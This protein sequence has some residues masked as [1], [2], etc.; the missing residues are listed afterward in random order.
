[1]PEIVSFKIT[2]F[3]GAKDV[4][5]QLHHRVGHPVTTLVGLNESGK[6]TILEA[7]SHFTT[8]DTT[9]DDMMAGVG[10]RRDFLSLLPIDLKPAFTGQVSVK[11]TIRITDQDRDDL[12]ALYARSGLVLK[13]E[14]IGSIFS[15]NVTYNFKDSAYVEAGS[16]AFW[17]GIDWEFKSRVAKNFKK[18]SPVGEIRPSWLIAVNH[19]REML[20]QVVYFPTFLVDLP[21]RIYLEEHV[22]ETSTNLYYRTIVANVIKQIPNVNLEAHVIKRVKD[23]KTKDATPMW[24]AKIQGSPEKGLVDSVLNKASALVTRRVLE[25]WRQ[26]I[27]GNINIDKISLEWGLDSAKNEMPYVTFSAS[28]GESR[29]ELDERSLGFRWFFSFLLFT[30]FG[31]AASRSKLFLFDEPAANLHVKAQSQLLSSFKYLISRGDNIVYSTHSAHMIEV[32][33]LS[34]AHIIENDAIDYEK[35]VGD[36]DFSVVPTNIRATPYRQFVEEYPSRISYFQ[37]IAEKLEHVSPAILPSRPALIVE[38]PSDFYALAYVAKIAKTKLKFDIV[39]AESADKCGPLIGWYLGRGLPFCVLLDDDAAGRKAKQRYVETWLLDNEVR[40][41]GDFSP[42]FVGKNLETALSP[43]TLAK[44][45]AHFA[46]AA[47]PT[48]KVTKKL[49]AAYFS[50]AAA[51]GAPGWIGKDTEKALSELLQGVGK[52]LAT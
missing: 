26:V 23:F 5:L 22:G 27:G 14:T 20:P 43:D 39:P 33:W 29:Y 38:G 1:M 40:T 28:D 30:T 3:R 6:T 2:N 15:I 31:G 18:L 34:G 11:T 51:L 47:D 46:S 41:L 19:L 48:P 9:L 7:L 10:R 13:R 25:A 45:Q 42:V 16:G 21:K 37:P 49:V 35:D 24:I 12:I 36:A 8:R 17:S 52:Q 44:V 32:E 4:T 50:E